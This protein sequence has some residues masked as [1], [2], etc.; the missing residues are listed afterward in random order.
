[1]LGGGASDVL[2]ARPLGSLADVELDTVAFAQIL[3]PLAVDGTPMEE[4]FLPGIVLDEPEPFIDSQR[5]NLSRHNRLLAVIR[6]QPGAPDDMR[7]GCRM[8]SHFIIPHVRR[9]WCD[10]RA[11]APDR[12]RGVRSSRQPCAMLTLSLNR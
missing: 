10:P 12:A 9:M 5:T 7:A 8:P 6:R 4:V 3:E 11:S 2:G 1:M